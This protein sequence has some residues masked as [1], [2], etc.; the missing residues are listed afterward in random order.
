MPSGLE[1]FWINL[2]QAPRTMRDSVM[3]H[4]SPTSERAR[5]QTVFNNYSCNTPC[6]P[7]VEPR[8]RR[9][10]VRIDALRRVERARYVAAFAAV[11][12]TY[13]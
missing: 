9:S 12:T 7:P 2:K 4:G 3:R 13:R 1:Q 5:S 6:N 8:L 11:R 10:L